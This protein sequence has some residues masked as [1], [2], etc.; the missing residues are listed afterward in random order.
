[1]ARRDR[2]P[3]ADALARVLPRE[4]VIA[5][6]GRLG[7]V[8]RQVKVD[9]FALVWA[10]TLGFQVGAARSL[11]ALRET[12]TQ[13]AGHSLVPSGFY[14]RLSRPMASLMR[15]LAMFALE[16]T[17]APS[18]KAS[19]R[20][21]RFRDL[22]AIDSTVVRLHALL[23]KS[24]PGCRTNNSEAAAKLHMVMSVVDGSAKRVKLTG[25]RTPDVAPW[26]RVGK[27]VEGRLLLFDLGYYRFHLFDRIDANGGYFLS[28]A[29]T[30]FNPVI[31][32]TN[33]KW[34]GASVD[35]V[36]RK[37]RDVLPK[38]QREHLDA[39]VEVSF[40]G[41]VYNGKQSTRT[42][43][44]RLVAVRNDQ[45]GEYHC[46]LT[47]LSA[48][49]LPPADIRD[50]YALRW[51]VELLFKAMKSQG[52]LHQL[53]SR[54]KQVVECLVWASVLATI[55]SHALHRLVRERTPADRLLPLLRWAGLFARNAERVLDVVLGDHRDDQPLLQHL[56]REAPDPNR[57]R[58]DRAIAGL[59][60]GLG[61]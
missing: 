55:V 50:T 60:A 35:V 36:G 47:N 57:R 13:R 11:T 34:R 31:V 42:R 17:A 32:A 26:R 10:L 1:M 41:R 49:D 38:L 33:R 15:S 2:T 48:D 22:L 7:V 59:A 3:I 23:S 19:G 25:E 6:A 16:Q 12:Y 21:A 28:R 44:F 30:T 54:K 27:W 9:A 14:K 37:L 43:T 29:K 56:R 8:Q 39:M 61:A 45:T 46:Y 51:Q 40:K 24:F 5:E 53:P 52:H 4:H 58:Q 18:S 20:L